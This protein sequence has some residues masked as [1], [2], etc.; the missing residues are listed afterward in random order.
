MVG[1]RG[2]TGAGTA[3]GAFGSLVGD[4][5]TVAQVGEVATAGF[6]DGLA[7]DVL[8]A[9]HLLRA[10]GEGV[11]EHLAQ[12]AGAAVRRVIR[13]RPEGN[14]LD[15]AGAYCEVLLHEELVLARVDL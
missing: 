10:C 4:V 11:L 7:G 3:T 13:R 14:R 1:L 12:V 2:V 9:G 8:H 5:E 15:G 6:A